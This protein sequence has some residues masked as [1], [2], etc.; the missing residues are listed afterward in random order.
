[1]FVKKDK[2]RY[3]SGCVDKNPDELPGVRKKSFVLSFNGGDIWIE[4]L[5]GMY[6]FTNHVLEKLRQDAKEFSLPSKPGII[7]FVLDETVINQDIVDEISKRL[8]HESKNYLKVA[9][10]GADRKIRR[11]LNKALRGK[12]DFVV[13]YFEDFE[14]A[15][16][17]LVCE[18][19]N[20][21]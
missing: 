15:K 2:S 4:H 13:G 18:G 10:V 11:L 14:V 12:C 6:Q 7:A 5:D 20:M 16:K 8:C 19:H 9:F 17:W 3:M 21:S 1:M